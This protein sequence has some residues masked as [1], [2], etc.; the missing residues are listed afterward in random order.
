MKITMNAFYFLDQQCST[1]ATEHKENTEINNQIG[2]DNHAR[3]KA[4]QS[5][6]ANLETRFDHREIYQHYQNLLHLLEK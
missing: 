3:L 4:Q 5:P 6:T 2:L 1:L